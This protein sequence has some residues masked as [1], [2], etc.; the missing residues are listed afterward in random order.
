MLPALL[1]V[2]VLAVLTVFQIA[3]VFGAPLGRFTFGGRY[4]GALPTGLRVAAGLSI[5]VYA[6]MATL[7]LDRAGV[8]AVY[9]E[10]ASRIGMWVVFGF[11]V[12]NMIPNAFSPSRSERLVMTPLLVVMSVLALLVALG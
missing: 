4:P 6:L 9:P 1:L 3:L 7:A 11:L 5:A 8:I 2:A 12:L 10:G